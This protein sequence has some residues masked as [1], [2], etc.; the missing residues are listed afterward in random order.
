[1][2]SITNRKKKRKLWEEHL[3]TGRV[4]GSA[5]GA[6]AVGEE[7]PADD[8]FPD[9]RCPLTAVLSTPIAVGTAVFLVTAAG[10][11]RDRSKFINL[12]NNLPLKSC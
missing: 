11:L 3:Y 6:G 12:K 4:E 10:C 5:N 2:G 8:F 9:S 7:C 1:M